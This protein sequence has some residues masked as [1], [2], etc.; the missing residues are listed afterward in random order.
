M[1]QVCVWVIVAVTGMPALAR[2][3][4]HQPFAG[5]WDLTIKASTDTYPSWM[6]FTGGMKYRNI[7]I[8]LPE[9]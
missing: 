3:N 4:T 2:S 5:R 7:A 1:R 6:E 8:S 9:R